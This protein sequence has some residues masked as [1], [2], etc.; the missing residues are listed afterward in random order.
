MYKLQVPRAYPQSPVCNLQQLWPVGMTIS[1]GLILQAP[2]LIS[3]TQLHVVS[4]SRTNVKPASPTPLKLKHYNLPSHDLMMPDFYMPLILFYPNP[5]LS[6]PLASKTAI[7][8]L[9]KNSLSKTLSEYYPFAGKLSSSG[10][11]VDCNDEGIHFLEARIAC[12]LS[13]ILEKPPV[14]DEKEGY[15]RLFPPGS[16]WHNMSCSRNLMAVQLNHFTCGGI[17]IAVSLSHR[18]AD[19]LTLLSFLSYWSRLSRNLKVQEKLVPRSPSFMHELLLPQSSDDDLT[20]TQFAA[21]EK[22]WITTEIVFP[23]SKIDKLKAELEMQDKQQGNKNKNYTRNELVTALLY[24]CAVFSA[25][26]SN[27]GTFT[28]SVLLQWVNM[29]PVIDPPLPKTSVGNLIACNHIPTD[30]MNETNLS[31]LVGKMRKGMMQLRGSKSLDG[32]EF[33]PLLFKYT[34][35]N[36]KPYTISSIC[37]LPFYDET[38]FGWGRPVKVAVVD[39]PLV[40]SI[41]MMDTPSKDGIKAIVSLEKQD[42]KYFLA[43]KEMLAY[44]SF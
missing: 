32:K 8:C 4:R 34:K 7:L 2:P 16:I 28:K 23:N 1:R 25:T 38:D 10:S 27:S 17:A 41:F 39:T 42:M 29:R 19:G 35:T 18:I 6:T 33:M 15:G 43:I 3:K 22:N 36:Y 31:T 24:R 20:A 40:N 21:P 30:T 44:A 5:Q 9:L 13:E 26:A 12:K 14:K 11:Y 37:K